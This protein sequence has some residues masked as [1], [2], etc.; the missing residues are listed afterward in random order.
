MINNH[1]LGTKIL[2]TIPDL[3][4]T[5]GGGVTEIYRSL[6]L[7]TN[8][9]FSYFV[10]RPEI[11]K[12]R[13]LQ[14]LKMYISFSKVVKDYDI[15]HL[16]PSLNLRSIVRDGIL[17]LISKYYAKKTIV[18]IHGWEDKFERLVSKNYI[19][20]KIFRF[21][22]IKVDAYILL[23]QIF[24]NKIDKL[25]PKSNALFY[26]MPT[27]ADDTY[28]KEIDIASYRANSYLT[29]S[30]FTLLFL[31]RLVP[32]KGL[33]IVLQTQHLLEKNTKIKFNTI[34]A[35][36]GVLKGWAEKQANEYGIRNIQFVGFVKDIKKH[37]IL[38]QADALFFP[39]CY[40]EG[41]PCSIL[42]SMLYGLPIITRNVGSI[43]E[44]IKDK[45]NGIINDSI[46][47]K[48]FAD[49]IIEL[50]KSKE[51][52]IRISKLNN[53]IAMNNFT[54]EIIKERFLNIYQNVITS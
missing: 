54:K 39:S 7:N 36:D 23:G 49:A 43:S 33:E 51:N 26:L 4:W 15:V 2:I 47:P 11:I 52:L 30:S 5:G 18:Y 34:I 19:I 8:C 29:S 28:L 42:E 40:F 22:F 14:L 44:W 17:I 46:S 24:K 13:L 38:L 31:S 48:Y 6:A 9:N 3:N 16:N 12:F 1:I 35:G 27:I 41:L 25:L 37:E 50:V 53:D 32:D 21:T 10:V 45:E 20:G